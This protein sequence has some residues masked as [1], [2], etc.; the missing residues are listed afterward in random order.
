M[1]VVFLFLQDW[2]AT[3]IPT[4]AI[5]VSLIGVFAILYVLGYSANT[6]DL[7]AI[8]LAITLVVDDAI[9]VVENVTRNLD[10][11]PDLSVAQATE[12]AMAEIA[13]PVVATTLILVAVFAPVGFVSGVTGALY[14]Q[15]ATTISVSVV[16]S[17]INA[18]T[19]S[20]AL[21][22]L[23]LRRPK[24]TRF[25]GFKVFNRGFNYA[26]DRYGDTVGFLSRKLLI[27]VVGLLV[28]F[29]A[30][31][32]F[33]RVTPSAF[34]P[35]E[36]QGYFFLNVQLPNGA[37]LERTNSVID[38]VSTMLRKTPGVANVI[39]VSGYS[40]VTSAQEADGG[41]MIAILKPW[42][43]RGARESASAIMAE[44]KPK[45]AALP[46]ADVSAFD[47]PSIPRCQRHWRHQLRAG[48]EERRILPA[49]GLCLP[50]P[51][52]GG[53]PEHAD[54][55]GFLRLFRQRAAGHGDRQSGPGGVCWASPPRQPTTPCRPT[56]ARNT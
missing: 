36:D 44:I 30:S 52:P 51:D 33:F 1:A 37:S 42:S 15:F 26:R 5:P 25:V 18:L 31:Y 23:M 45:L 35:A 34:L 47:P 46:S 14:R 20:P 43:K 4:I 39:G 22:A 11:N 50:Q 27:P 3:I 7:F 54:R 55:L 38:T 21:C 28:V 16:I 40:I 29:G 2:R 41:L 13:G 8:V 12:K 10:E 49:A 6:I 48:G 56:W 53:Q 32:L 24:P 17:A 9:V 19:L